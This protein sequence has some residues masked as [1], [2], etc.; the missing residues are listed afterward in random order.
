MLP[1]C[2]TPLSH[3]HLVTSQPSTI[4]ISLRP[5]LL[6]PSPILPFLTNHPSIRAGQTAHVQGPSADT[7]RVHHLNL[8]QPTSLSAHAPYPGWRARQIVR[9]NILFYVHILS[10]HRPRHVVPLQDCSTL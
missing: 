10:Q 6:S 4:D 2:D 1:P 9:R 3:T 5:P 7:P 8:G